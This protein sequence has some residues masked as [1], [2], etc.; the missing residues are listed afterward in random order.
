MLYNGIEG[1]GEV[2]VH[3]DW[4]FRPV[5]FSRAIAAADRAH[6]HSVSASRRTPEICPACEA[7]P[8][9]TAMKEMM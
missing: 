8:L 3:Q 2:L 7:I 6:T 5:W 1:V 4:E 9:H